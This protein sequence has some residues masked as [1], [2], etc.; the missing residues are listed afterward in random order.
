MYPIQIVSFGWLLSCV[1]SCESV[2][3]C[4]VLQE[5]QAVLVFLVLFVV[6]VR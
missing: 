1:G 2:L 4:L 5:I 3:M 6:K